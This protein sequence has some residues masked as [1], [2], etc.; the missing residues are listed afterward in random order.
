MIVAMNGHRTAE[1]RSLAYHK[2][3]ADRLATDQAALDDARA[4]V[5]RWRRSGDVH[6]RYADAWHEL[7]QR[8]I[9]EV[10]ASLVDDSEQ[11]IALRQVSP[12]AGLIDPRR[13]W[14]I[15]RSVE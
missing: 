9:E 7:L 15:W 6:A 3:I 13:R 11:M 1:R 4:R 12:F 2:V 5:V 10:R 14:Q 8:P